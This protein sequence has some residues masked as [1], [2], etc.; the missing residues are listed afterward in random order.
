VRRKGKVSGHIGMI[1]S[2]SHA[3]LAIC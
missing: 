1:H 2:F 3:G